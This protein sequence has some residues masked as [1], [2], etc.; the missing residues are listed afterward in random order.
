[1]TMYILGFLTPFVIAA[2]L[3]GVGLILARGM[4]EEFPNT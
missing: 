4:K 2:I 1:M 3:V